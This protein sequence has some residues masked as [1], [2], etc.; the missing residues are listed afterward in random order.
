MVQKEL[1]VPP[2]GVYLIREAVNFI[3]GKQPFNKLA[4]VVFVSCLPAAA[5]QYIHL[6]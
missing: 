1:P 6:L 3:S 2:K 4:K 5:L